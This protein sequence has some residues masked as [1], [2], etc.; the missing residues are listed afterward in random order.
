MTMKLTA[1][2]TSGRDIY[3]VLLTSS[4]QAWNGSAFETISAPA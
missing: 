4:G 3:A 2:T 1:Y